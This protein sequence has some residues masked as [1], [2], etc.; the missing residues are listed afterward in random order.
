MLDFLTHARSA[1]YEVTDGTLLR[2]IGFAEDTVRHADA[3]PI[4]GNDSHPID[5]EA[6]AQWLLA[7]AHRPISAGCA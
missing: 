7:R 4:R 2:S 1:G 5:D 3:S 6:Y